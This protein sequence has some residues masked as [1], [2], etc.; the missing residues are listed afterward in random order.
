MYFRDVRSLISFSVSKDNCYDIKGE[1]HLCCSFICRGANIVNF[2]PMSTELRNSTQTEGIQIIKPS[3]H[4]IPI[5][6]RLSDLW[7]MANVKNLVANSPD[8]RRTPQQ[9]QYFQ[10]PSL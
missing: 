3:P 10:S 1:E 7:D 4:Y 6:K 9:K 5:Q 2:A 8:M